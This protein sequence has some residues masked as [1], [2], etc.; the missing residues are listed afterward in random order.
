MYLAVAEICICTYLCLGY[1]IFLTVMRR[2][3]VTYIY[4]AEYL[5][6]PSNGIYSDLGILFFTVLQ[7][8]YFQACLAGKGNSN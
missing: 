6:L 1:D 2:T 3:W 8:F 7:L 4:Q 5:P